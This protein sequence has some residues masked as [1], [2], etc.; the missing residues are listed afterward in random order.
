[1]EFQTPANTTGLGTQSRLAANSR[2]IHGV[3]ILSGK[4]PDLVQLS[5]RLP[6]RNPSLEQAIID[7]LKTEVMKSHPD[8]E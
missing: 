2:P 1:M 5:M 8:N 7:R 3:A 4:E 6:N